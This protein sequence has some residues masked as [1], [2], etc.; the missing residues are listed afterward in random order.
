MDTLDILQRVIEL[1]PEEVETDPVRPHL[2]IDFK[3]S[4]GREIFILKNSDISRGDGSFVDVVLAVCCVAYCTEVPKDEDELD[5]FSDPNGK[6]AVAY[7]VWSNGWRKGAGRDIIFNIRDEFKLDK[8]IERLITLSP[9]TDMAKKFH[10][11]NGAVL[12]NHNETS[13]NFEYELPK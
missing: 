2:S 13:Y 7:T 12:L 4:K 11:K 8:S 6:I 1:D 9:L 5:K 10:L 3:T